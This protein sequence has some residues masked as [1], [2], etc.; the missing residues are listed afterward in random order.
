MHCTAGLAC[1]YFATQWFEGIVGINTYPAGKKIHIYPKLFNFTRGTY[2]QLLWVKAFFKW[3]HM[4]LLWQVLQILM[5]NKS[6]L[7]PFDTIYLSGV[8]F[9]TII[10]LHLRRKVQL[11][12]L[13]SL[14]RLSIYEKTQKF[15]CDLVDAKFIFF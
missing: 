12:S 3:T 4:S 8:S 7:E 5:Q 6:L 2:A 1:M 15:I 9:I 14:L 11:V 10:V 13:I